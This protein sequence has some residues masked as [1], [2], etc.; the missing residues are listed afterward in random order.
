[1]AIGFFSNEQKLYGENQT[2][3]DTNIIYTY[4]MQ[5]ARE[6]KNKGKIPFTQSF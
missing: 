6:L 3:I 1:M 4:F 5:K 2:Y